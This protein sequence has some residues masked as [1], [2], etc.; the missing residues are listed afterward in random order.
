MATRVSHSLTPRNRYRLSWNVSTSLRSLDS[1]TRW[2]LYLRNVWR[3]SS[4]LI[5][6][7]AMGSSLMRFLD[8]THTKRHITVGRTPLDEWSA[9][10]ETSTRQHTTLTA[11]IH[12]PGGIRT[13]NLSRRAAADLRLRPRGSLRPVG[14]KVWEGYLLFVTG[15]GICLSLYIHYTDWATVKWDSPVTTSNRKALRKA[16][17]SIV[18]ATLSQFGLRSLQECLLITQI[19]K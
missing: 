10:T 11:D 1:Y 12:A 6:F 15:S 17:D 16:A 4:S 19:L 7:W 3:E 18:T 13:H 2:Y 8:H 14:E 5:L 9:R